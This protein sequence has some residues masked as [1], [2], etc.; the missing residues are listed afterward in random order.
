[1]CISKTGKNW[2]GGR[3]IENSPDLL[4]KVITGDN[5]GYT[6]MTSKPKPNRPNGSTLNHQDRKKHVKFD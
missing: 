4:K 6:V 3:G 2:G 1:M 5:H